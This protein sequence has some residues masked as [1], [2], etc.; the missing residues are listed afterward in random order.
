VICELRFS[1]RK[2]LTSVLFE[3]G[4]KLSRVGSNA[5]EWTRVRSEAYPGG[6]LI[7]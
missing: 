6:V 2:N 4:S 7:L 5:F 3:P 1:E